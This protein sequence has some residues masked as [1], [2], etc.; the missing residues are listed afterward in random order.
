MNC[1]DEDGERHAEP[2]MTVAK[3]RVKGKIVFGVY[4]QFAVNLM[5]LS[6]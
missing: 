1:I 4:L 3:Q 5:G 2:L 6:M